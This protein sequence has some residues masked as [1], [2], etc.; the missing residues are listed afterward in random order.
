MDEERNNDGSKTEV[1]GNKTFE[2]QIASFMDNL[3]LSYDDVVYKIPY[4]RL[5]AMQKD[6]LRALYGEKVT[7]VSGKDMANRRKR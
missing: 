2:G 4:P 1:V 7:E 6:K 5:L 3:K